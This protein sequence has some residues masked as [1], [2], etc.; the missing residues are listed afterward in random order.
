MTHEDDDTFAEAMTVV[1]G[2]DL[3]APP[4]SAS[5]GWNP[6]RRDWKRSSG[7]FCV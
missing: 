5:L 1:L 6:K 4:E 2:L 7:T 3:S